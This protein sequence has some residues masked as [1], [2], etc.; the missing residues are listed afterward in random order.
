ML[1]SSEWNFSYRYDGIFSLKRHMS[2]ASRK[3]YN[4]Q[5]AVFIHLVSDPQ[6]VIY[7]RFNK[8]NF[9]FGNVEMSMSYWVYNANISQELLNF[10]EIRSYNRISWQKYYRENRRREYDDTSHDVCND[11]EVKE[12]QRQ[13]QQQPHRTHEK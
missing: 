2:L 8:W 9:L 3:S 10:E 1:L 11:D 6:L 13:Q 12:Q 4:L 7:F 5:E